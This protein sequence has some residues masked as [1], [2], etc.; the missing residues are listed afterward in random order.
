MASFADET[1]MNAAARV[2]SDSSQLALLSIQKRMPIA[3]VRLELM[4]ART[5]CA[6][7]RRPRRAQ[8]AMRAV[9]RGTAPERASC[10]APAPCC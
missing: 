4:Q 3:A 10:N 9:Q 8:R 6:V 7:A 1:R 5:H 2:L